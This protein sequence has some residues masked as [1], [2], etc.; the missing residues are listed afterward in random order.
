MCLAFLLLLFIRKVQPTDVSLQ[1][2]F[3]TSFTQFRVEGRDAGIWMF[4]LKTFFF[5]EHPVPPQ[6]EHSTDILRFRYVAHNHS[7]SYASITEVMSRNN[8]A[9]LY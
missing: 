2:D 1:I 8:F 9:I 4:W 6:T 3:S 5:K 7:Y